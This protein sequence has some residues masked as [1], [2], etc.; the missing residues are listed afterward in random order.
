LRALAV[1]IDGVVERLLMV[2]TATSMRERMRGLLGH[3]PLGDRESMLLRPCRIVHTFGM[4]Y[5]ID[6][7]FLDQ[8]GIVR[9]IYEAVPR[10]RV[11]GC[12][13]AWQT[14]EMA[15]GAAHLSG[16]RVGTHLPLLCKGSTT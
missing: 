6:I 7:V 11:R 5:P 3:A 4:T 15:A 8:D 16:L 10:S 14:L 1:H 2:W 9:R 13:V 12:I